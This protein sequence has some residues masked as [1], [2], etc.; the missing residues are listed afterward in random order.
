[1]C[2]ANCQRKGSQHTVLFHVEDL[3]SSHKDSRVN[4]EFERR[5]QKHYG[6]HRRV[7]RQR[8]KIYVHLG[9]EIEYNEKGK[10]KFGMI[11]YVEVKS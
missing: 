9:M 5:L 11:N 10:I 1:M 4:N 8:G 2:V 6:Q 3:K 7:V